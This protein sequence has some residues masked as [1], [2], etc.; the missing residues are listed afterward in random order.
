VKMGDLVKIK[1]QGLSLAAAEKYLGHV[2]II[3]DVGRSASWHG[4]QRYTED[5]T[6]LINGD[7]ERFL[8]RYITVIN[9]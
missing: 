6:V 8:P 7:T 9:G 1:D 2:G 3:V 5:V 4:L